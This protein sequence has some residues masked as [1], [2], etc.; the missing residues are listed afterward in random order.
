MRSDPDLTELEW[1]NAGGLTVIAY[2]DPWGW[3]NPRVQAFSDDVVD[4]V[5]ARFDLGLDVPVISTGGSMGGHAS[6]LYSMKSRHKIAV[7]CA[8]SDL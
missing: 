3:M 7:P 6:L 8:F 4:A 2:Q 5:R 1:G